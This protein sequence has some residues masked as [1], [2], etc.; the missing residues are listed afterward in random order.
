M[1]ISE[2][3]LVDLSFRSHPA[4]LV[5]L[6]FLLINDNSQFLAPIAQTHSGDVVAPPP[7]GTDTGDTELTEVN[8]L[9][10]ELYDIRQQI[11]TAR[12]KE[13]ELL[14]DL[15]KL[16]LPAVKIPTGSDQDNC[17]YS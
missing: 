4:T 1:D 2:P 5:S 11:I 6:P 14:S 16:G 15:E 12:A 8:R 13:R 10:R 9:E 17:M 3:P 7:S